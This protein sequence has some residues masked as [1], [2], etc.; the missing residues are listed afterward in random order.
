[1]AVKRTHLRPRGEVCKFLRSAVSSA[2]LRHLQGADICPVADEVGSPPQP[3][4]SHACVPRCQPS[5]PLAHVQPHAGCL[6]LCTTSS[7]FTPARL[8]VAAFLAGLHHS[9]KFRPTLVVCP[10][11][12]MRQWLRELRIWH[13]LF[14]VIIMH[15][16]SRA[17]HTAR[18]P[19]RCFQWF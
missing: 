16:S 7:S 1:M 11:T 19:F 18:P 6:V 8:Q 4:I 17:A 14:R 3:T 10:A 13:P 9:R 5:Q 12:V 2:T 15:E